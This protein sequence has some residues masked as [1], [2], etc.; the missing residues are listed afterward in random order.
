MV[1]AMMRSLCIL[2]LLFA[3]VLFP[4]AA[5]AGLFPQDDA[6]SGRDA[7]S[8]LGSAVSIS[9]RTIS[10]EQPSV[11]S[12]V[13]N[14]TLT[15]TR[16]VFAIDLDE[17]DYFLFRT[18][19][20]PGGPELKLTMLAPDGTLWESHSRCEADG[21]CALLENIVPYRGTWYVAVE[22]QQRVARIVSYGLDAA[23]L[24]SDGVRAVRFDDAN[25]LAIRMGANNWTTNNF[26]WAYDGP[27]SLLGLRYVFLSP[28]G[29]TSRP[30]TNEGAVIQ[31]VST[32][33]S[34]QANGV[35][36]RDNP[37][38]VLGLSMQGQ[39]S[40]LFTVSFDD[41]ESQSVPPIE[42]MLVLWFGAPVTGWLTQNYVGSDGGAVASGDDAILR[43]LSDFQASLMLETPAG[44][45]STNASLDF[46]LSSTFV[47]MYRLTP[48]NPALAPLE[49]GR[50]GYTTPRG[51]TVLLGTVSHPSTMEILALPPSGPWRFF[52][53][54]HRGVDE[55]PVLLEGV[56]VPREMVPFGW[57]TD[58]SRRLD[59]S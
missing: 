9:A 42:T 35:A 32:Q 33:F 38:P 29:N 50:G 10:P 14:L 17:G 56:Q 8:D 11:V 36:L 30:D 58:P 23:I 40:F 15:D 21:W 46:S 41:L 2:V 45:V 1:K 7:G 31:S 22:E 28:Y 53:Q 24:A 12:Y 27:D 13:A 34:L 52:V 54:E 20:A 57:S 48:L 19:I 26:H 44:G 25:W 5:V 43:R 51:N 47:G 59:S 3:Q 4:A 55:D 18:F 49:V 37:V 16:D 6:G 39:H